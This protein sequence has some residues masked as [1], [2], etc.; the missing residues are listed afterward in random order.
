M[1]GDAFSLSLSLHVDP[2]GHQGKADH[3][4]KCEDVFGCTETNISMRGIH[5]RTLNATPRQRARD[6]DRSTIAADHETHVGSAKEISGS[7][8]ATRTR[9]RR[10]PQMGETI[11]RLWN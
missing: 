10:V 8:R 2:P 1:T 6:N 9:S 3:D 7:D 11:R 5:H 4:D